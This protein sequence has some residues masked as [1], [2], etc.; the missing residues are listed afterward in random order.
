MPVQ[1]HR[2]EW[3]EQGALFSYGIDLAPIGR[4]GARYVDSILRGTSPADLP[5]EKIPKIEFAINL[6]TA[7]RLGIKIP[8]DMIIRADKVYR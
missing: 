6:K 2:K 3:V 1:A 5:V 4:A 7:S 8:Q